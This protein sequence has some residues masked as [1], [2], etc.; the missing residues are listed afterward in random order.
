MDTKDFPVHFNVT[1]GWEEFLLFGV[2]FVLNQ[3]CST[4]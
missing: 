3:S 4:A 1:V 2:F